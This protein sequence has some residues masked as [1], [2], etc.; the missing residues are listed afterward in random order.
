MQTGRLRNLLTIQAQTVARNEFNEEIITFAPWGKAWGEVKPVGAS[1]RMITGADQ[2][3]AAVDHTITIRFTPGITVKMRIAAYDGRTFEVEGI[4]DPDGRQQRLR[5]SCREVQ[6][7]FG[8]ESNNMD[9]LLYYS[10]RG[11]TL[12]YAVAGDVAITLP[13]IEPQQNLAYTIAA[14]TGPGHITITDPDGYL[15]NGL[16]LLTLTAGQWANIWAVVDDPAS[17]YAWYALIG[18]DGA[19]EQITPEQFGAIGDG[20]SHPLSNY[21]GTLAAAQVVY[22]H[23][24]S[25]TNELDWAAIQAAINAA[26]ALNGCVNLGMGKDYIIGNKSLFCGRATHTAKNLYGLFGNNARITGKGAG[27]VLIDWIGA[28]FYTMSDIRL[29]GDPADPP[30]IGILQARLDPSVTGGIVRSSGQSRISMITAQGHYRYATVL[31]HHTETN[32]W[33]RCYLSNWEPTALWCFNQTR[34]NPDA[35]TSPNALIHQ[36]PTFSTNTNNYFDCCNFQRLGGGSANGAT[37][38]LGSCTHT[39]FVGCLFDH[40]VAAGG[41]LIRIT[42]ELDGG[43]SNRVSIRN[44]T[45]HSIY[46]YGVI[47]DNGGSVDEFEFV[48]NRCYASS[49]ADIYAIG[50]ALRLDSPTI[51]ANV[52]DLSQV[53]S[54]IRDGGDIKICNSVRAGRLAVTKD[55]TCRITART[56][57]ILQ[58][59]GNA[60]Q[61]KHFMFWVDEPTFG[62]GDYRVLNERQTGWGTPAGTLTRAAFDPTTVTTAQLAERVN[63]LI[64]DLRTHGLIGS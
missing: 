8:R 9:Q 46:D 55:I 5:L 36:G 58:L 63:A 33:E 56:S 35:K 22:P 6:T 4:T 3:Q 40:E 16:P 59:T 42:Q 2:V 49:L 37:V 19:S 50:D 23:A 47:F 52:I 38:R 60:T 41:G 43:G 28:L 53:N 18:G 7:N 48:S 61:Q 21:F 31:N 20:S 25:L 17:G 32:Y 39:A 57:D 45:L 24:T 30:E 13:K 15:I 10:Q 26:K 27:N 29:Y 12:R 64:A 11:Q 51:H 54:Y 34:M 62:V 44:S 14:T 1:E